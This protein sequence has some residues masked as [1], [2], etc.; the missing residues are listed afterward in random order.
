MA[1]EGNLDVYL[2]GYIRLFSMIAHL[3]NLYVD[4]LVVP[5]GIFNNGKMWAI[6]KQTNPKAIVANN[7]WVRKIN[8]W[9]F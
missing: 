6:Q 3:V 7:D 4:L 5:I 9:M 8:G 1:D 2:E